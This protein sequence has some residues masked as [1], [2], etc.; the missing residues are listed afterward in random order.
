MGD[1]V[2]FIQENVVDKEGNYIPCI[3]KRGEGGYWKTDWVWGKDRELADR[4]CDERNI[5]AGF[6]KKEAL[7][8]VLESMR[9]DR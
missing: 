4:L 1:L 5:R 6:S 9:D 3:A 8:I 2:I 7:E